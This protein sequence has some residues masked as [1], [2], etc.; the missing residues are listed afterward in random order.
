MGRGR[1]PYVQGHQA[2][3]ARDSACG[4]RVPGV[5]TRSCQGG[6]MSARACVLVAVAGLIASGTGCEDLPGK[7]RE[8]GA[9]IGGVGGAVAGGAIAKDNRLLGAL[10]GGALG[11]GGGYLVGANWDKIT[12]DK[13]EE[14]QAAAKK[15]ET[16]PAKV[17]DVAKVDTADLN[18]DGFVTLD[19]VVALE[20]AGLK[21]REIVDRLEAT[22]QYFELTPDQ[23]KYLRD[24]GVTD[25]VITAMQR[26]NPQDTARTAS[27][28]LE[29]ENNVDQRTH[30]NRD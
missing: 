15:A 1:G 7:K 28:T 29:A 2:G 9:V 18:S 22:Q 23:E 13:K 25:T 11:A 12:G 30:P 20:K 17:E 27:G 26:M 8:Q 16:N 19:E 14:A 24:R 6:S 21:D 5:V 10:I 3:G 4:G